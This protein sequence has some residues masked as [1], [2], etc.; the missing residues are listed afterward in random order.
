[1]LARLPETGVVAALYAAVLG[2]LMTRNAVIV[3]PDPAAALSAGEAG[4]LLAD[5]ATAAGAPDGCVQVGGPGDGLEAAGVDRVVVLG[6]AT[7]SVPVLVDRTADPAHVA[8]VVVAS[9]TFDHSLAGAS[10]SVLIVEEAGADAL[11]RAFAAEGGQLCDP[12]ELARLRAALREPDDLVGHDVGL[13]ARRA[14]IPLDPGTRVLLAPFELVALEE[15]LA[16]APRLPLL[17]VVRVPDVASG[18]AAARA[19]RRV[20]DARTAA[21]HSTDWATII[22]FGSALPVQRVVA[23]AGCWPAPPGEGLR[24]CDLVQLTEIAQ[25]PDDV[26]LDG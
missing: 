16:H 26:E 24:P 3:L 22:A 11:V 1:V 19:V 15:P 6:D 5:A 25:V 23:N 9:K 17:G 10:E 18:I 7:G 13:L 12:D 14:G 21:I 20:G 8:R 4:R 2:C